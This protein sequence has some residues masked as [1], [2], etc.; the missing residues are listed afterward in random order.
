MFRHP[1]PW[2]GLALI[3]AVV[4]FWDRSPGDIISD[5]GER[6]PEFP[7][8]YMEQMETRVFD[9]Q[10]QLNYHLVTE[11]VE[12]Y[13]RNPRRASDGDYSL[14]ERPDMTVYPEDAAPWRLRALKGRTDAQGDEVH[15][16]EQVRAWQ[17]GERGLTE[18]TTDE[19][20]IEPPREYAHTDKAVKMRAEQ[21]TTD[22]VGMQAELGEDR[23]ELLSDVQSLYHA[24]EVQSDDTP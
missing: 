24:L 17:N 13:Q 9:A 16:R 7:M 4:A 22:A 1:I 14:I 18:I 11:G 20:W 23:I 19:L 8:A 12:H 10:G 21:G 6:S 15:L 2:L 3:I 5:A